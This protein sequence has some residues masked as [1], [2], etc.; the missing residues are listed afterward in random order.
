MMKYGK[1]RNRRVK[2]FFFVPEGPP[3]GSNWIIQMTTKVALF[4]QVDEHS[5][6]VIVH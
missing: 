5:L 3:T 4:Y 2:Q 1:S 6:F